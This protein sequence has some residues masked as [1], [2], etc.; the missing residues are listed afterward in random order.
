MNCTNL[1]QCTDQ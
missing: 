1:V